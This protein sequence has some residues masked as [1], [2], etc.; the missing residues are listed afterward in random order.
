[1]ANHWQLAARELA[2]ILNN[3][4]ATAKGTLEI[5]HGE[6]DLATPL[7]CLAEQA[8]QRLAEA[9]ES[10]QQ[11]ARVVR[12]KAKN[13]P[14]GPALALARSMDSVLKSVGRCRSSQR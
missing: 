8:Q 2:D 6:A 5:L 7:E 1:M 3:R 13:T 10:I 9:A 14:T 11:I 12:L 4:I